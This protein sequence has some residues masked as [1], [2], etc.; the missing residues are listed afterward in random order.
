MFQKQKNTTMN[1]ENNHSTQE[2]SSI[3]N[4]DINMICDYFSTMERQGPGSDD[5]TLKALRFIKP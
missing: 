1:N 4:F 2:Q 5:M 3:H